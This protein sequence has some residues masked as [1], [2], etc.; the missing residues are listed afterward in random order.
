[1]YL[2]E[3][4]KELIDQAENATGQ[5]RVVAMWEDDLTS[6]V[7]SCEISLNAGL[8]NYRAMPH[9]KLGICIDRPIESLGKCFAF[10]IMN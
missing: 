7:K 3:S 2:V 9:G 5:L 8:H 4:V 1:M 10:V 6:E